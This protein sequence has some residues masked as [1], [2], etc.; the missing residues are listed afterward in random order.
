[1][2]KHPRITGCEVEPDLRLAR[3][4]FAVSI[5]AEDQ[6]SAEQL[7][8]EITQDIGAVTQYQVYEM[9]SFLAGA[10]NVSREIDG[11]WYQA[12]LE[13]LLDT[14][15]PAVS[16]EPEDDGLRFR[17]TIRAANE[18]EAGEMAHELL[19]SLF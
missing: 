9:S 3:L 16:V 2:S 1:M 17:F 19:T 15:F 7:R 13:K 10:W 12:C 6:G 4:H 5:A 8:D 18:A 11:I 14:N